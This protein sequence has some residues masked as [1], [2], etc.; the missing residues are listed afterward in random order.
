MVATRFMRPDEHREPEQAWRALA[1]GQSAWAR[2]V[3]LDVT[4]RMRD[5]VQV[6]AAVL[7]ASLQSNVPNG[8][9]WLSYGVAQGYAGLALLGGQLDRCFPGEGW[10]EVAH[11]HLEIAAHGAA[12][13]GYVGPGAFAGLSGLAFATWYLSR[14][15]ERYQR[16]TATLERALIRK[17]D[18]M[19]SE[20][21]A[22][23]SG[24]PVHHF[25]V[26]SGLSGIALYLLCRSDEPVVGA[27][28]AEV[29]RS[30]IHLSHEDN[31]LP[32]WHCPGDLL[33]D[34]DAVRRLYPHGYLNCGLAHGIP[35][36]LGVL[37]LAHK[38]GV[39]C[40]GLEEA[41]DRLAGWLL[42][43]RC[44]DSWGANWPTAVGLLRDE[45]RPTGAASG[46][47]SPS[48]PSHAAWCYGSPGIARA[49]YLAG[50]ALRRPE[51]CEAAI[52]AMQA[53]LRRPIP[54]RRLDSPTFCH[55]VAGLLT[56]VLRFANDTGIAGMQAGAVAI[57]QQ[58]LGLHE[59]ESLLGFRSIEFEGRRVDQPGLLDGAPGVA[60]A[61]L[62][63][64]TDVEPAW[65]RL[66]LL[67]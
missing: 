52:D 15:G 65:D 20:L 17:A 23:S 38:A 31:G 58:L 1:G 9:Q 40:E 66:F 22:A 4:A 18:L 64:A 55:G 63:A 46:S 28:L 41:I 32:R 12:A 43:H 44:D 3:A 42:A 11:E 54:A 8:P 37:A 24:V 50:A 53:V 36:P 67:S 47:D 7:E 14:G 57:T 33:V 21:T 5:P 19:T 45:D 51:Y 13:Q 29:T 34:D 25:D 10:D 16:L 2:Q 39:E 6:E 60:L 62:A 30:L 35:G 49:L 27:A 48:G 56:I 61:L 59:P 26:I